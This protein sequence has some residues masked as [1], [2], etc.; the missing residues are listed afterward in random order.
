M[1]E[2]AA[3]KHLPDCLPVGLVVGRF[4]EGSVKRRI[5]YSLPLFLKE[6]ARR[7]HT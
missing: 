6:A 5:L 3:E 4:P 7:P 1:K 2:R